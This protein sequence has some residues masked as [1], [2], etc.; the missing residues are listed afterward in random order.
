MCK[1]WVQLGSRAFGL[2]Q[3]VSIFNEILDKTLKTTKKQLN[4]FAILERERERERVK[5]GA[6]IPH[7]FLSK[8]EVQ[9]HSSLIY[10]KTPSFECNCVIDE[11]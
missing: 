3:Y 10:K 4:I 11:T 8:I 7:C 1:P 6:T 2:P 5:L 9:T